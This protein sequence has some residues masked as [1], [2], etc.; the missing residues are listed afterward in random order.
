M[1]ITASMNA[2]KLY[3]PDR[4]W[5]AFRREHNMRID[6][7]ATPEDF[8]KAIKDGIAKDRMLQNMGETGRGMMVKRA[9]LDFEGMPTEQRE[10]NLYILRGRG[11]IS[12]D[13]FDIWA[14]QMGI[15]RGA[16]EFRYRKFISSTSF[17]WELTYKKLL[18]RGEYSRLLRSRNLTYGAALYRRKKYLAYTYGLP[19]R[20][21]E[22]RIG[23]SKAL[24]K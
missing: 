4:V 15:S 14:S 24:N 6:E 9:L 21:W 8:A 17:I 18:T 7:F 11:L 12:R 20:G 22:K 16:A 5:S 10:R 1:A 19:F 3:E 13:E 23:K 2:E